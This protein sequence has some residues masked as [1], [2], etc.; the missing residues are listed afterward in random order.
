MCC[1]F[2]AKQ[3]QPHLPNVT[4]IST[5]SYPADVNLRNY[6]I[7]SSKGDGKQLHITLITYSKGTYKRLEFPSFEITLFKLKVE[8]NDS[9]V[10]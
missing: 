4:H 7:P 6:S 10:S 8:I 5:K 2:L 1:A 9:N 3:L